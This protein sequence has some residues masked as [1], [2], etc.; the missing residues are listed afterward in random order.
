MSA[1]R[2]QRS[3]PPRAGALHQLDRHCRRRGGV[4][5]H[6]RHAAAVRAVVRSAH[7]LPGAPA[8]PAARSSSGVSGAGGEG[9]AADA[10]PCRLRHRPSRQRLANEHGLVVGHAGSNAQHCRPRR[11]ASG[12]AGDIQ[13]LLE[14]CARFAAPFA[15]LREPL[16]PRQ[17]QAPQ[18]EIGCAL[19]RFRSFRPGRHRG[20]GCARLSVLHEDRGL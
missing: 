3:D 19:F 17:G 6:V 13:P 16:A 9:V 11:G 1:R 14:R 20:G 15:D 12:A 2:H 5:R 7:A 8:Q 10:R 18:E 4:P